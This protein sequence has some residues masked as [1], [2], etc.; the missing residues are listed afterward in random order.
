MPWP[1]KKTAADASSTYQPTYP[2]K[3]K[4]VADIRPATLDKLSQFL[5]S[6]DAGGELND[7]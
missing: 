1:K 3:A 6:K 5:C 7:E 4:P 2:K